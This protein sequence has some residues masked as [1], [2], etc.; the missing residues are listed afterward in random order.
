VETHGDVSRNLL[1]ENVLIK[2]GYPSGGPL[3][4]M[5]FAFVYNEEI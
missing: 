4:G 5:G 1:K 3:H 2:A